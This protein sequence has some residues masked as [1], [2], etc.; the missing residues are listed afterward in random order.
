[1]FKKYENGRVKCVRQEVAV[2]KPRDR[3]EMTLKEV[4]DEDLRSLGTKFRT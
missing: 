1:V 3:L 4:L 2:V